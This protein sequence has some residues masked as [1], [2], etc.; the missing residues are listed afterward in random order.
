MQTSR[1]T[2]SSF[3]KGRAFASAK[4]AV[5]RA[6]DAAISLPAGRALAVPYS[7]LFL[8][9]D[10]VRSSRPPAVE[11]IKQLAAMIEA[12]GLLADLHVSVEH[13]AG[14]PT[15][16]FG[17]EAG[18]RRWRAL[19]LLVA[20]G[21]LH[22]D[23]PIACRAV[24]EGAATAVSL[25]ENLAHEPMS[26]VD[27]FAAFAKLAAE[28]QSI[29]AIAARFGVTAV[30]V[31][32]RMKLAAVAPELLALYRDGEATLDQMMALACVDDPKRQL[33]AWKALPNYSR[34]PGH[35]KD[36]LLQEEVEATDERVQLI[37]LA[38]YEASGGA[39]RRDL[40]TDEVFLSDPGL[41]DLLVAEVLT[42]RAD[43]VRAEGVAFVETMVSMGYEERQR[44]KEAPPKYLPET[45]EVRMQREVLEAE[46][47]GVET[48][49]EAIYAS[50]EETDESAAEA[51]RL[52]GA[53]RD[54]RSRIEALR[55]SRLDT[56][57]HDKAVLGAIV[58][59]EGGKL[60]VIRGVMTADAAKRA[61]RAASP[62]GGWAADAPAAP[63]AEYS[64]KLMADLT[65]HRTAAMQAAL[66]MNA[67]VALAVLTHRMA[68]DLLAWRGAGE[69]PVKVSARACRGAL[70]RDATN[71]ADSAAA[72]VLDA[73]RQR[74][75]N[76]LPQEQSHWL[77]WLLDQ[78]QPVVLELLTFCTAMTL[79]LVQRRAAPNVIGDQI[80][81]AL[82]LDMAS[83]W[84]AGEA[85][86]LDHVPKGK[87]VEVVVEAAG[88][89]AAKD[90]PKMKKREACAAAAA[91][92]LDSRWLPT[93]L[94][95][96]KA[97][98]SA[99]MA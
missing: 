57:G 42:E 32:R 7:K 79:D 86:F 44:F 74:W 14:K 81:T 26:P 16:R 46:L 68:I 35:L 73:Q 60:K 76:L 78:P 47:D 63:K 87:L 65:S 28:G 58:T 82:S 34:T 95:A 84:T 66:A 48:Q 38:R 8:S 25:A 11:G 77:A 31:Q 10:N 98:D 2:K 71:F 45:D 19:G 22:P 55:Q 13:R 50:D 27:E 92:L 18:G 52:E 51:D 69:Q 61:E 39:L 94:R 36:K 15:G 54:V 6:T 70:E 23:A 80:A 59:T 96:P 64:E 97:V 72:K 91:K 40:F 53:E 21:K 88:E 3:P 49:L 37:T 5:A 29:E 4:S 83:W 20:E 12:E 9:P 56:S 99:P 93:P 1:L 85:N 33:A 41:V 62:N 67:R 24:A 30:H 75:D 43:A 90:L 17:V 89:S